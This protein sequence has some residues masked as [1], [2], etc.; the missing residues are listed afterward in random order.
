MVG[1]PIN[2]SA[3]SLENLDGSVDAALAAYD[4]VTPSAVLNTLRRVLYPL[5]SEAEQTH[6]REIGRASWWNLY[7]LFPA[8]AFMAG[9]NNLR[10]QRIASVIQ[11]TVTTHAD[12]RAIDAL[13]L[14]QEVPEPIPKAFSET[15][16]N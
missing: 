2:S 9:P 13:P 16:L 11:R 3:F 6:L 12:M 15:S 10:L 14:Y 4:H 5:L 8:Y 7:W 1:N